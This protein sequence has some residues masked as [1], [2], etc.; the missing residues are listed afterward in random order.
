MI[1]MHKTESESTIIVEKTSVKQLSLTWFGHPLALRRVALRL[2]RIPLLSLRCLKSRRPLG[3]VS[4]RS[5]LPLF[6]VQSEII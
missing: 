2:T 5:L 3:L 4:F 6:P 1:H